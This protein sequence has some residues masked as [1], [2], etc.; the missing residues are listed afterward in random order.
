MMPEEKKEGEE[1]SISVSW[2]TFLEAC[3]PGKIYPVKE[4]IEIDGPFFNIATPDLRLHCSNA[5]CNGKQVFS[6]NGLK[7][8][9][10]IGKKADY[11]LEYICS[12]CKALHISFAVHVQ[13]GSLFGINKAIKYGEPSHLWKGMRRE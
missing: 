1:K 2:A 11:L 4:I 8:P 6:Y 9:I 5:S 3:L 7:L 12:N 10:N 13:I